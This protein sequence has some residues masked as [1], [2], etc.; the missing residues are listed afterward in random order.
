MTF[1]VQKENPTVNNDRNVSQNVRICALTQAARQG[2][3]ARIRFA[4]ANRIF[5]LA[6]CFRNPRYRVFRKYSS[7]FTTAKTCSTLA[8]T[9]DF[10]RSL[11]LICALVRL[12]LCFL[13]DGRWLICLVSDCWTQRR[14]SPKR[15]GCT[16][17]RQQSPHQK[18]CTDS[19]S[20]RFG[21]F[22]PDCRACCRV[23]L[24]NN[25]DVWG[26][27]TIPTE[28]CGQSVPEILFSSSAPV[29]AHRSVRTDSFAY[30]E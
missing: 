14:K 1:W 17:L 3:S 5:N 19:E 6:V 9:E 4:S 11:R 24:C 20:C 29:Q 8:R 10:S 15:R 13:W 16:S 12:E 28:W 18:D 7:C 27:S 25:T 2:L 30:V 21:A 23:L 22:A 26:Q